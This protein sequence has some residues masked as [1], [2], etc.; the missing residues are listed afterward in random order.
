[1][2]RYL[3][4]LILVAI[5]V[6]IGIALRNFNLFKLEEQINIIDL[7]TLL[8]TIFLA[9]Y[10]PAFLS[11]HM[12]NLRFEKEV[13]IKKIIAL[14]SSFNEVNKLVTECVQKNAVSQSKCHLIINSFTSISNEL[15]TVIT[16]INY[17]HPK[18]LKPELTELKTF[19]REYKNLVTG[20]QFQHQNFKYSALTKKEEEKLF[21]KIDHSICMLIFKINRL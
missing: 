19:R 7:A 17:S 2:K 11:K 8:V 15:E 10:I 14:Q 21:N 9:F 20:G 12:E 6:S 1:M 3:I 13:I 4:P 5:G 16:L 18:K